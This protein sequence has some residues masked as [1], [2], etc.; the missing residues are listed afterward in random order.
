MI[1]ANTAN[2]K[3]NLDHG[4]AT[5]AVTSIVS[6]LKRTAAPGAQAGEREQR[7]LRRE[8]A[9][10]VSEMAAALAHEVDQPLTAILS[11][12]Q[13][14]Q[15]FLAQNPPALGDLQEL[16]AE[17]VADSTRAH[18]IVRKM[19]QSARCEPPETSVIDAGGLVREVV[20]LLRRETEAVGAAITARIEDHLPQLQGD[21]VRLQQVLV[22]LLLN[23]LDAVHD[24]DAADRRVCVVVR[25]SADRGKVRIAI[26]DHGSGVDAVQFATLFKPF[27]TSKPEGLGLGL[28]ISRTIVMA[29]GGRL[30]AERNPDR[31]MTFHIELPAQSANMKTQA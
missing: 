20:R 12:A 28:S 4:M 11:N 8:R 24:C 6:W 16:L 7:R 10:E 29:H 23:A 9:S 5:Q 1:K 27:V 31:G 19:R 26:R 15:R 21:A 30:W 17:V 13:A 14:A 3:L 18:A 2:G 25:A 22:N